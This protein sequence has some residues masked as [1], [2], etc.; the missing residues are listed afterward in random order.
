MLIQ[1]NKNF[2]QKISTVKST[3]IFQSV[4]FTRI[5]TAT[6]TRQIHKEPD[7]RHVNQR[8]SATSA[9]MPS[10]LI[11]PGLTVPPSLPIDMGK[12]HISIARLRVF[13]GKLHPADT[14]QLARESLHHLVSALQCSD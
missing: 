13:A 12:P 8:Q 9:L 14:G 4:S 10:T 1:L 11:L 3:V 6:N 7:H 5:G 2:S